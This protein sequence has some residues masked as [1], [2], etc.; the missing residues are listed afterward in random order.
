M[1]HSRLISDGVWSIYLTPENGKRVLDGEQIGVDAA[2]EL[3]AKTVAD[4]PDTTTVEL[5]TPRGNVAKTVRGGKSTYTTDA[6]AFFGTDLVA[7]GVIHAP[8]P[9]P[10]VVIPRMVVALG[11][12]GWTIREFSDGSESEHDMPFVAVDT[13]R[14]GDGLMAD[15]QRL[16]S[17]LLRLD[18]PWWAVEATWRT[19]A[20][21][22]LRVVHAIVIA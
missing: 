8:L 11:A 22:S 5:V 7:A 20:G 6:V 14:N 2:R 4:A 21:A 15:A 3:F 9:D 10:L 13:P 19:D 17:D 12:A 16:E 18:F 1:S